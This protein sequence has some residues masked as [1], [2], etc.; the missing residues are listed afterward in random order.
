MAQGGKRAGKR[1]GKRSA[2]L[3]T[4]AEYNAHQL[5]AIGSYITDVLHRNWFNGMF[6]DSAQ[7]YLARLLIGVFLCYLSG[8]LPTKK[9][10]MK[11]M[12]ATHGKTSQRYIRMAE[13]K[14]LLTIAQSKIDQRVDLL[15]PTEALL[16][17]VRKELT[18][19]ADGLRLGMHALLV[20]DLPNTGAPR[21]HSESAPNRNNPYLTPQVQLTQLLE[22]Q[23]TKPREIERRS[24]TL[25]L[26]PHNVWAYR[27]P[28]PQWQQEIEKYSETIRLAPTNIAAYWGRGDAYLHVQQQDQALTDYT[29]AIRLNPA[30]VEGYILRARAHEYNGIFDQAL[31]DYGKAIRLAPGSA[32]GYAMRGKAYINNRDYKRAL[33]DLDEAIRLAPAG[34]PDDLVQF[35]CERAKAYLGSGNHDKADADLK[36]AREISP[37]LFH[38]I[39]A[40]NLFHESHDPETEKNK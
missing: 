35:Y 12:N 33:E 8:A 28:G 2:A 26:G 1:T 40:L 32:W 22:N 9:Q 20:G 3:P 18:Q 27:D 14:G 39:V 15:C 5:S 7:P 30:N 29:E 25:Q 6:E 36:S 11:Y 19:L 34:K 4:P 37:E 38:A 31:A 13:E 16:A 24:E 23:P 10:A 21:L 17:L